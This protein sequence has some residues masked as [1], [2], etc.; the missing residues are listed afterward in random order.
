MWIKP[1]LVTLA[2]GSVVGCAQ[3]AQHT[4]HV[5]QLDLY[6]IN[7]QSM[8]A[9]SVEKIPLYRV[10]LR[11]K[12]FWTLNDLVYYDP[13]NRHLAVTATAMRRVTDRQNTAGT[14]LTGMPFV[15]KS[16]QRRVLAGAFYHHF[17]S[18]PVLPAIYID[19]ELKINELPIGTKLQTKMWQKMLRDYDGNYLLECTTVVTSELLEILVSAQKIRKPIL[20][21]DL[22]SAH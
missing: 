14:T 22:P 6:W 12:P 11:E 13:V 1:L 3:R 9:E 16:H 15:I 18:E 10:E 17:A 2:I 20:G 21:A 4:T 7:Q 5:P 19:T 8:D